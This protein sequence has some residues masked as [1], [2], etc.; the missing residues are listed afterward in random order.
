MSLKAIYTNT[1]LYFLVAWQDRFPDV[2]KDIFVF[3]GPDML[4]PLVT[5]A[6][7]GGETRCDS[8]YR[9]G[10][11][12][13]LL[14]SDWWVRYGDDD[15]LAFAFEVM[16]TTGNGGDYTDIGCRALCHAAGAQTFGQMDDG[17]IDL[18]YWLAGRTNPIRNIFNPYDDPE[19]PEQGIPGY[20]DDMYIDR[21]GGLTPDTGVSGYRPNFE[22]AGDRPRHIYRRDDDDFFEPPDPDNTFNA[23][24]EKARPNNGVSFAYLWRE[25]LIAH[26]AAITPAD[27]LN[28]AIQPDARRWA[29]GDLAPGYILTY[30]TESRG[31]VR[32]KGL[33]NGDLG[34]WT[35]ELARA[36]DTGYPL[37]DV[38]FD[39]E[40]GAEYRFTISVF[41]ASTRDHWGS[42]TQV[43]V[44]EPKD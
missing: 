24:R 18:W 11:Q 2:L 10:L 16:P 7:V 14:V 19:D 21:I 3:V 1:H 34:A 43:L 25:N 44:F 26:M 12:D 5:C 29:N 38:I 32:G 17:R 31:D 22:S 4:S 6:E 36:L 35:L 20:L 15:K 23:F 8:L 39:P 9:T 28:E 30:P 27:T 37:E 33:F 42:E 41:D 13:S 40:A